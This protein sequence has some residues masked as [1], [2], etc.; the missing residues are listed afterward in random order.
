M[1][2]FCCIAAARGSMK[3]VCGLALS[4]VGIMAQ[5]ALN[6]TLKIT[7]PT[8]S[9][10][11]I[12]I[13]AVGAVIFVIAFFGCCGAWKESSCMVTMFAIFLVLAIIIDLAALIAG[14][15]FRNEVSIVVEKT[16]V[17]MMAG[18]N[19]N[20][21]LK[22]AVDKLQEDVQC[23]GVN[24]TS[25]WANFKPN[26][27]SVPDSCCVNVTKDC[28]LNN[29]KNPVKVHQL[30]NSQRL[31]VHIQELLYVCGCNVSS[32]SETEISCTLMT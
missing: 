25:D 4:V 22:K 14:Y 26:K 13:I 10:A 18:Y 5:V 9:A 6:K 32:S 21:E 24:S 2:L 17:D 15:V 20:T 30:V 16:L 7:D 8:A 23:C 3:M 19:N 31:I 28:G 12:V 1:L 27:N 11:P 29:M